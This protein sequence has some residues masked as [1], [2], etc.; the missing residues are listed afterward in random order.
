MAIRIPVIKV[1]E[2]EFFPPWYYGLS[3]EEWH[4]QHLVFMPIPFNYLSRYWFYF[5]VKWLD[6]QRKFP[7]KY[8]ERLSRALH[9][10]YKRGFDRGYRHGM[11]RAFEM[12]GKLHRGAKD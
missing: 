8:D 7:H 6:F 11:D 4:S 1:M 10:H 2:G 5:K 12:I 3:H 9:Y